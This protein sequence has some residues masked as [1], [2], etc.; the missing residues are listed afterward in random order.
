[1]KRN[2]ITFCGVV[3]AMNISKKLKQ[4]YYQY[5]KN[6]LEDALLKIT[7]LNYLYHTLTNLKQ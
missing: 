4:S 5:I 2:C 6:G 3:A 7:I 1:M